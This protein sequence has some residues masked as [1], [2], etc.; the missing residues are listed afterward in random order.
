LDII[1]IE[2]IGCF[3][4]VSLEIKFNFKGSELDMFSI[5]M[6]WPHVFAAHHRQAALHEIQRLKIEGSLKPGGYSSELTERGS[7]IVTNITLPLKK[8]YLH[9]LA[10]GEFPG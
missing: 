2:V 7:L 1:L 9:T 3:P 5:F 6:H 10:A 8:D 4:Q